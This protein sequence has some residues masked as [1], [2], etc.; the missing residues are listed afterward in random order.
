[1]YEVEK[2]V[3][4]PPTNGVNRYPWA[5]MVE[6]DSFFIPATED[7]INT[8]SV[9]VRVAAYAWMRRHPETH[10]GLRVSARKVEG[11]V[12]VWMV[13]KVHRGQV[14]SGRDTE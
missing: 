14:I 6:G 1:M 13:A 8:V 7:D 10:G 9:R 11:G 12:R 2:G 3:A 5:E 4:Q